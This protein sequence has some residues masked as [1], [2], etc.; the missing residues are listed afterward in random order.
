[1]LRILKSAQAYGQKQQSA[2]ADY[3][4]PVVDEFTGEVS[5]R[6][7]RISLLESRP[8]EFGQ[9]KGNSAL[10][11]RGDCWGD[12]FK[13]SALHSADFAGMKFAAMPSSGGGRR[14]HVKG[15]L[16]RTDIQIPFRAKVNDIGPSNLRPENGI[17]YKHPF[18]ADDNFG[19][20]K[21]HIQE[22]NCGSDPEESCDQVSC[23]TDRNSG[24]QGDQTEKQ[25]H[26]R[27]EVTTSCSKS[28]CAIHAP[29]FSQQSVRKAA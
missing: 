6:C 24:P 20:Y 8:F 18:S 1:M 3:A 16:F 28:F 26:S 11:S 23:A 22:G 10:T 12:Q 14:P 27:K 2:Q 21:S 9:V 25:S 29:I 15:S 13:T 4:T 17:D 19:F 7:A 5:G